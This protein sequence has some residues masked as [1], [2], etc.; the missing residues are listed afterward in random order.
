MP[1]PR[2]HGHLVAHALSPAGQHAVVRVH[3]DNLEVPPAPVEVEVAPR[4]RP[5]GPRSRRIRS[6][7]RGWTAM[8]RRA[9]ASRDA[10]RSKTTRAATVRPSARGPVVATEGAFRRAPPLV[11]TERESRFSDASDASRRASRAHPSPRP[12][13]HPGSTL[14][15][16]ARA[17]LKGWRRGEVCPLYLSRGFVFSR[18]FPRLVRIHSTCIKT[19]VFGKWY[20]CRFFTVSEYSYFA[21]K[22]APPTTP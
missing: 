21:A 18:R 9:F 22:F 12:R 5:E 8:H 1:R 6:G 10:A 11:V 2:P 3:E 19:P 7:L 14:D 16:D 20:R 15:D 17:V 13:R 4:G